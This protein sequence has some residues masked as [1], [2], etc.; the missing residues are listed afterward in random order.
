MTQAVD[1]E[2]DDLISLPSSGTTATDREDTDATYGRSRKRCVYTGGGDGRT[3]RRLQKAGKK[4][5]Q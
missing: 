1:D 4:K 3:P 5:T 2:N